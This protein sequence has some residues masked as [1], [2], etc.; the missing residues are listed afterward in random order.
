VQAGGPEQS[1]RMEES[2]FLS[3]QHRKKNDAFLVRPF[4]WTPVLRRTE[5]QLDWL[6]KAQYIP[7]IFY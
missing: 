4:V 7:D 5:V 2:L 1:L 3:S 6:N